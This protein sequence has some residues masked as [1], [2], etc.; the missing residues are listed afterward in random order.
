[1]VSQGR[2]DGRRIWRGRRSNLA[3]AAL[4]AALLAA[5]TAD[6]ALAQSPSPAGAG[7]PSTR[8]ARVLPV[9]IRD[10][11]A[12]AAADGSLPPVD[13]L[14]EPAG[15]SD[16]ASLTVFDTAGDSASSY[17][18]LRSTQLSID[19]TPTL[20]L[21]NKVGV[22]TNPT[23]T[24]WTDPTSDTASYWYLD[25]NGDGHDDYAVG[26]FYANGGVV[27]PMFT[28]VADQLDT[29]RC[30]GTVSTSSTNATYTAR[31]PMS[32]IGHAASVRWQA[33][34]DYLDY[35]TYWDFAP[36]GDYTKLVINDH[37]PVAPSAP[38]RPV[39]T[40]TATGID[41]S[42]TAP[43]STGGDAIV[44]YVLQYST[45]NGA[46]WVTAPDAVSPST[47]SQVLTIVPTPHLFR[48][49]AVNTVGQGPWSPTSAPVTPAVT[50]PGQPSAPWATPGAGSTQLGWV[51][52]ASSGSTAISDYLVQYSSNG[53]TTWSTFA[54]VT[55]AF[56][57]ASVTGLLP[58]T[59]Y[60]FRV[61]AVS[62]IGTGPWSP[63]SMPVT[64]V[65]TPT[66]PGGP[67]VLPLAGSLF[68]QW[69]AAGSGGSPVTGYKVQYRLA[70]PAP[71]G[72]TADVVGGSIVDIKD[73]PWQVSVTHGPWLCGGTLIDPSW[74]VT[75]AHCADG[76][77]G[78]YR[79]HAGINQQ[80]SMTD[81]NAMTV[82]QVI[83]H[84]SYDPNTD[85]NDIALLHLTAP[86]AAGTPVPLYL[87]SAGPLAGTPAVIS[88]WGTTSFNGA[89]S[90]DLRAAT[91]DVLAGPGQAC[92][93]YGSGFVPATMLCAG[94]AAG[95]VD[96]CQGDSGGPL[97]VSVDSQWRLAGVTSFGQGC[98]E[99]AFPGVYTR[100]SAYVDWLSG[101]VPVVDPSWQSVEVSCASFAS[102]LSTT[103]PGLTD[104]AGYDV[105]VAGV[106][107]LGVGS[108]API[109]RV[110]AGAAGHGV[111]PGAP[112]A[113]TAVGRNGRVELSW[114]APASDGGAPIVDYAVSVTDG[115]G[116]AATGVTGEAV[117]SSN[118]SR[119]MTFGGLT[120]GTGYRFTVTARNVNGSGPASSPTDAVVPSLSDYVGVTP[121]RVFDSRP[122]GK[123]DPAVPFAVKV[124]G[125][126]GV[127]LDASA[128]SLTITA[129]RPTGR[130]FLTVYS[131]DVTRPNASTLNFVTGVSV[132][133]V[134]MATP[135]ADGTVCI[136]GDKAT[137]VLLD[138]GGYMP[139]GAPFTG[140]TPARLLD[141]RATGETIDDDQRY[142]KIGA[143]PAGSTFALTL[144]ERGGVG[145]GA[146]S[147][148]LNVTAVNPQAKG[149]VTAYPCAL[150]SPPTASNL[151]YVAG[152]N[153]AN[154]VVSSSAS[155]ICLYTSAATDLIVDVVGF[156]T[157]GS[158]YSPV[159]P[160]R[161]LDSRA[162]GV[163]FDH[164]YEK[165]GR[166]GQGI[167]TVV[168]VSARGVSTTDASALV[169]N[170]T[171]VAPSGTGFI[172]VWPCG[173]PLPQ[174]SNV[175][176]I[177]GVNQAT[178][179]IVKPGVTGAVCVFTSADIDLVI[180]VTG[181]FGPA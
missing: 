100:V 97:V 122:S 69:G 92:G 71:P 58:A 75:A 32:C 116:G 64:T 171:A 23:S 178:S 41:V 151:N 78:E 156:T 82:S 87:D 11:F 114:S 22:W 81:A 121:L 101:Y 163:S 18:D 44:D 51:R 139:S 17:S 119:T 50:G 155:S 91:V 113:V 20:T 70:T 48:V 26:Y 88:G 31:F 135:A 83:V 118:G 90:N 145:A 146:T 68:A 180:D 169:L 67:T 9:A 107:A 137:D 61:A 138:V 160:Q 147:V 96:S 177:A 115:S 154:M 168:P 2:N 127:P 159:G 38:G 140:V 55:S 94:K 129:T 109:A 76:L 93:S 150:S 170:V 6:G 15:I 126:G 102:C 105:R 30:M 27:A 8:S 19:A 112:T 34:M 165:I 65:G 175:N 7:S 77:A 16:R 89:G 98:A 37:V 21:T 49:A 133:N 136:Y 128:V 173:A 54:D 124:T 132:A 10:A 144:G 33:E 153:V 59:P 42:W 13:Q 143:L 43:T 12:R 134:V 57:T 60:V 3:T 45:T 53:G 162:S 181:S 149:F 176:Y 40:P 36:D 47:N 125:F 104:G 157:A 123:L 179:V 63:A 158:T 14:A 152:V 72:A 174:S 84:P 29:L 103:L 86:S 39:G 106:N 73:Y 79:V 95:G 28:V 161:L 130:G 166:R 1:M 167:T 111:V 142:E 99:A 131:C 35:T 56:E 110:T 66:A 74:V 148:V 85:E 52:P 24:A 141:T 5:S 62:S 164:R 172:T 4:L 120:N 46:T 117:R 80:T 108:F 25:T